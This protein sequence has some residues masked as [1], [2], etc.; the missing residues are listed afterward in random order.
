MSE[1]AGNDYSYTENRELSWLKFNLRV[2]EEADCPQTPA[3][4][5]LKFISIFTSNLDEFYMVRV[6]SLF[7]LA[8]AGD[9]EPDNKS[10]LTCAEQL[11]AIYKETPGLYKQR[12]KSYQSVA[13]ALEEHH[14]CRPCFD[15]LTANERKYIDKYFKRSVLPLLSP[16]VVDNMHPFPHLSNKQPY[17]AALLRHGKEEYYGLIP[18][19]PALGRIIALPESDLRFVLL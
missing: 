4:E 14:I 13:Q 5:R 15:E 9:L 17:V 16:Q 2:L 19:S 1:R 11:E 18:V 3:F 7:D 12:D 8:Q 6:G 10:G